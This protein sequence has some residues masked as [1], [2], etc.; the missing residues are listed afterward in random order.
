LHGYKKNKFRYAA[1]TILAVG[2]L[3]CLGQFDRWIF[4]NQTK[5]MPRWI[6]IKSS[7]K[8]MAIGDIVV[9][10]LM[11]NKNFLIKYIAGMD[12][13][14]VCQDDENVLWVN[15]YPVAQKNIQ[16]YQGAPLQQSICQTLARDELLVLGDHPDSYDGRYF[17]PIKTSDVIASVRLVWPLK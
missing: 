13:D 5:S 16:K 4:L 3:P 8:I 10:S 2:L 9:L 12:G 6:Y 15:N 7:N 14:E 17:G 1:I 11:R